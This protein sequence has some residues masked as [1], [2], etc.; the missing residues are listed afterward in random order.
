MAVDVS[1]QCPFN[2]A[3]PGYHTIAHPSPSPIPEILR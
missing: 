1:M 2:M 3:N